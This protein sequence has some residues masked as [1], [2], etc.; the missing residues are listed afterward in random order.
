[1]KSPPKGAP[2][3]VHKSL[4]V[5]EL[6]NIT[7]RRGAGSTTIGPGEPLARSLGYYGKDSLRIEGFPG[8]GGFRSGP[9]GRP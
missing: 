7:G 9:R 8:E 3:A 1:M 4:E 2:P 5:Q 6:G